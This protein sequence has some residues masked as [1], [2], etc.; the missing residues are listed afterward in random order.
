MYLEQIIEALEKSWDTTTG[1]YN[2][3][4]VA[5]R[6]RGQ[7]VTSSLVIWHFYGGDIVR[8]RV[9][10]QDI[11]ETHYYNLLPS[12]TILDTTRSQYKDTR[13]SIKDSPVDLSG[14]PSL[15][16]KRLADEETLN[17]YTL[18]LSKVTRYLEENYGTI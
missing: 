5:N 11:D 2:D 3:L 4:P 18:L 15:A 12:G 14:Y 1:W 13:I 8:V 7:C 6:A 16:L 17:K 10:G 9:T